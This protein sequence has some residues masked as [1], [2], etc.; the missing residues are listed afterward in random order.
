MI[1]SFFASLQRRCKRH[2]ELLESRS[3]EAADSLY[4]AAHVPW[5]DVTFLHSADNLTYLCHVA[6]HCRWL[7]P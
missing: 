1:D 5:L 7:K 3:R 4:T 6:E 2:S